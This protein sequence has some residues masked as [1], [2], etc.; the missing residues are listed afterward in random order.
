MAAAGIP[1][2]GPANI[3]SFIADTKATPLATDKA[4]ILDTADSDQLKVA[5][6]SSL[7]SATPAFDYKGAIDCSGNPN[8]PAADSGDIYNVSVAGLIGGAAGPIVEVGD[9]IYCKVNGTASG[10]Q[11]AVGANWEIIQNN[12]QRPVEAPAS[13]TDNA[14]VRFDGTGGGTIQ[15]GQT[16]ED[17]SGNVTIAGQI[18]QAGNDVLDTTSVDDTT[19]EIDTTT[20]GHELQ[21]KD[22]S[23]GNTQIDNTQTMEVAKIGVGAAND[24][25]TAQVTTGD[26][27][28]TA[29]AG[30]DDLIVENSTNAGI[31]ILTPNNDVSKLTMGGV[32]TPV[33]LTL[34]YASATKVCTIGPSTVSGSL[35][36]TYSNSF[37][38]IVLS[39]DGDVGIPTSDASFKLNVGG[40][41][42]VTADM[43]VGGTATIDIV[44]T[45]KVTGI[46]GTDGEALSLTDSSGLGI[47]VNDGGD[48]V[49]DDTAK[50][51]GYQNTVQALS[52][53]AN[54]SVDFSSG[55]DGTV[56]VAG[57]RTIDAPTNLV[58]G[59]SGVF[60]ITCDGTARTLT[61]ASAY[62]LNGATSPSTALAVS[63][64]NKVYWHSA[65]GSVVD[66]DVIYGV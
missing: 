47:H 31:S 41:A 56:T 13:S 60:T 66:I 15:N 29:D 59:S 9:Q 25:G 46:S 21:V 27:G 61:W 4:I 10:T 36:L 11:A 45:E 28:A 57:N 8:Y 16:T 52:D 7:V 32:T 3:A 50:A 30:S 37:G 5:T 44:S 22:D 33:G 34:Q 54:I 58:A 35:I 49:I 23:I 55:Y 53:G 20:G 40:N 39:A 17:D 38:G 65:D 2:I 64:I 24:Q 1:N 51:I 19:I 63:S 43:T 42:Q 18:T 62:R 12:I 26:S 14:L 48:I 6:I